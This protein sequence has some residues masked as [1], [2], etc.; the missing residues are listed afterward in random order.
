MTSASYPALPPAIDNARVVQFQRWFSTCKPAYAVSL[1]FV[2]ALLAALALLPI[3]GWLDTHGGSWLQ[4]PSIDYRT[5]SFVFFAVAVSP[6]L[7]TLFFQWAILR[8]ALLSRFVRERAWIA[9]GLSAAIFGGQHFS[10]AGYI[11]LSF[12]VGLVLAYGFLLSGTVKR[13][14]WVVTGA[15][16]ALN[17]VALALKW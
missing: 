2:S 9:A 14:Y 4:L 17:L 7:E 6:L 12:A 10:S 3:A 16:C 1:V 15:H 8:V 13:A 5:W 11:L